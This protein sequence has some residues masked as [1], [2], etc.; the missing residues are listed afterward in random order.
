MLI[1]IILLWILINMN[2]PTW[3]Y[4]ILGVLIF[5]RI[6]NLGAELVKII[7]D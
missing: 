7:K 5:Y 6:F 1:C 3:T 2:A 4:A